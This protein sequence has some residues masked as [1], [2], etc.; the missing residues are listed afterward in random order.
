ME[1][2][3]KT[4]IGLAIFVTI[5]IVSCLI[6]KLIDKPN[7]IYED[8]YDETN[9]ETYSIVLENDYGTINVRPFTSNNNLKLD[10]LDYY[11]DE[12]DILLFNHNANYDVNEYK[13]LDLMDYNYNVYHSYNYYDEDIINR[14]GELS[15]FGE[16]N[17]SYDD[18]FFKT[19]SLY[20]ARIDAC[21]YENVLNIYHRN[22]T[23]YIMQDK[24]DSQKICTQALNYKYII[25]EIDK[26]TKVNN[27]QMIFNE[28]NRKAL[29]SAH[30]EDISVKLHMFKKG[31][32]YM[33]A[34]TETNFN[35]IN[36]PYI[37]TF[38][39]TLDEAKDVYK[40]V[41]NS[42]EIIVQKESYLYDN[43]V[44]YIL[45]ELGVNING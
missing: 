37:R 8:L 31:N 10:L 20:I 25:I 26:N 21:A 45:N 24:P 6:F 18:N 30:S 36:M 12:G 39:L 34:F 7:A 33:V 4:A 23:L 42:T 27:K 22:N 40:Y 43:E 15:K 3:K 19:K 13:V 32:Q 29:N 35:R 17:L 1:G 16:F 44:D 14:T 41:Y 11:S 2:N 28:T 5:T 38:A 9:F